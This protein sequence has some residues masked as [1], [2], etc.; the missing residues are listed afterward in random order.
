MLHTVFESEDF[1]S[2]RFSLND[3]AIE[4]VIKREIYLPWSLQTKHVRLWTTTVSGFNPNRRPPTKRSILLGSK[5]VKSDRSESG[6]GPIHIKR[7][8]TRPA[9][10]TKESSPYT[11]APVGRPSCS[12]LPR[13]HVAK[14][15]VTSPARPRRPRA[16]TSQPHPHY[17]PAHT[18]TRGKWKRKIILSV[19]SR[20]LGHCLLATWPRFS[21]LVPG[22]F[23]ALRNV[24][25]YDVAI[26]RTGSAADEIRSF[27]FVAISGFRSY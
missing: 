13:R 26:S 17:P 1:L 18:D 25:N 19:S 20:S 12:S 11:S 7:T 22:K 24:E 15:P 4:S 27:E 9:N 14:L 16:A 3:P 21:P 2:F 23:Y 6:S 10:G 8:S 5:Q